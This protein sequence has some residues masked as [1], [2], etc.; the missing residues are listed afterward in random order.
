MSSVGLGLSSVCLG[1]GGK[2][3][4]WGL[5]LARRQNA[6]G[7]GA[8]AEGDLKLKRRELGQGQCRFKMSCGQLL[9]D[10]YGTVFGRLKGT[11]IFSP[12]SKLIHQCIGFF[13]YNSSFYYINTVFAIAGFRLRPLAPP[14]APP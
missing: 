7:R 10:H 2:I 3:G 8:G 11:T 6:P 9:P 13:N 5:S 1:G 12:D 14:R 4:K